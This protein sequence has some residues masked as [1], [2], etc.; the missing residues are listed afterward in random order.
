[1]RD[2][3]YIGN[4]AG[5]TEAGFTL[6]EV[7]VSLFIFS[8]ISVGAMIALSTTLNVRDSAKV[9]MAE[10]DALSAA[11]RIMADDF[12]A[13]IV[14]ENRDGL[15][16][17]IDASRDVARDD[18]LS[19]VRR[20]R[21]NPG[22]TYPRGDLLRIGYRVEEG[23][24]IRSFLAHE[25]P[26]QIAEPIDRILLD[27]VDAMRILSSRDIVPA[28]SLNRISDL[29]GAIRADQGVIGI[30]LTHADGT[31]T[32]HLFESEAVGTGRSFGRG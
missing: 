28:A 10:L 26:G 4:T 17:F 24:L 6:V 8:I 14:R 19:F 11:R 29:L 2:P 32:T 20:G 16:G 31:T 22:G 9:R 13:R 21:P 27:N 30:E 23:A 7:L 25:N 12:A 15:G 3:D 5:S 18:R 1:M